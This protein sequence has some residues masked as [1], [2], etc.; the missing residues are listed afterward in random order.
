MW[1][2]CFSSL[3]VWL[4]K[5]PLYVAVKDNDDGYTAFLTITIIVFVIVM[6]T[7]TIIDTVLNIS[8]FSSQI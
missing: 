3:K 8:D 7:V 5:L 6:L 1:V 4:I 2:S